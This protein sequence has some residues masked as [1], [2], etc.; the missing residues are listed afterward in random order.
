MRESKG[1]KNHLMGQIKP[2]D[3]FF[4]QSFNKMKKL[5]QAVIF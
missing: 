5:T 1:W 4:K 3:N 2:T